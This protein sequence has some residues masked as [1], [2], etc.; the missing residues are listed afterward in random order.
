M[1]IARRSGMGCAVT[2]E[3]LAARWNIPGRDGSMR[4]PCIYNVIT[5]DGQKVAENV[6]KHVTRRATHP[7]SVGAS[8]DG[9]GS[10]QS[11]ATD[12]SDD[13]GLHRRRQAAWPPPLRSRSLGFFSFA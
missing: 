3:A 10:F 4:A 9:H 13:A 11:P 7:T 2:A 6:M 8:P 12:C 5:M 1:A